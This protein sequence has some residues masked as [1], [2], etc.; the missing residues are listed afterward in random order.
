[1]PHSP[2]EKKKALARVRRIRGQ[3]EALE[4][5]L[6]AGAD[7]APVLQQ[8]AALRGAINGLMSEVLE[9]HIRES[10]GE[11]GEADLRHL[12]LAEDMTTLVRTYL[13]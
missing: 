1:M 6:E 3:A 8:L 11:L 10:L 5:A 9:S 2:E 7:C 13:K 12:Q 4:R